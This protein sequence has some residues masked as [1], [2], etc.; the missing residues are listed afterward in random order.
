MSGSTR[1][2]KLTGLLSV[3]KMC[4]CWRS[5][6]WPDLRTLCLTG[7]KKA[8]P[9]EMSAASALEIAMTLD[10]AKAACST[11]YSSSSPRVSQA[12]AEGSQSLANHKE[13]VLPVDALGLAMASCAST[14]SRT[15]GVTSQEAIYLKR[16]EAYGKY[17]ILDITFFC[18]DYD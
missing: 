18:H 10:E 17:L 15:E 11:L 12:A 6:G 8:L 9:F 5:V 4:R 13:K 14:Y 16:N 1:R 2:Q 3:S 7:K